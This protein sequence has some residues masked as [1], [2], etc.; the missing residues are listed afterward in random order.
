MRERFILQVEWQEIK[1]KD[2]GQDDREFN[3]SGDWMLP[4]RLW[5]IVKGFLN[6][7]VL[8]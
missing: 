8:C 3:A 7:G 2:P 5:G 1:G 6:R 4:S